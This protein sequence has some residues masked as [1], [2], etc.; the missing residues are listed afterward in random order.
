M[1]VRVV[2]LSVHLWRQNILEKKIRDAYRGFLVAKDQ[3][4]LSCFGQGIF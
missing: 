1:W 2:G 4:F 3:P